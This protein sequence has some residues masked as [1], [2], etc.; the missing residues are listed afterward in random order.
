MA[1]T[2]IRRRW[3]AVWRQ[4]IFQMSMAMIGRT[5]RALDVRRPSCAPSYARQATAAPSRGSRMRGRGPVPPAA[6]R[7][8]SVSA[9]RAS[10]GVMQLASRKHHARAQR[11]DEI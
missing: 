10:G 11:L 7:W 5:V 9:T 2:A 1:A 4:A 8:G 3:N 6:R